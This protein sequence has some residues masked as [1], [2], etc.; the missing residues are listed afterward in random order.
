MAALL[1]DLDD[2][3]LLDETLVL[4]MGEFGRTPRLNG[5]DGRDHWPR[6]F[7]VMLAGGGVKAGQVVGKSD[8][9]GTSPIER[10][11]TPTDLARTVYTL[12]GINPDRKFHT[13]DGRPVLVSS[14]GQVISE[15]L[16]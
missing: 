1:S 12:L 8:P 4:V 6:A 13:P 2:R 11:V 3:A 10:P 7:S 14:G 9:R 5:N 16:V 15:C